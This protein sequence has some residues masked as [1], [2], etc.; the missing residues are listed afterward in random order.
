MPYKTTINKQFSSKGFVNVDNLTFISTE[1]KYEGQ[2]FDIKEILERIGG[3]GEEIQLTVK[4]TDSFE[5]V[6]KE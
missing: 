1:K 3:S 2:A 5:G 4:L 6:S